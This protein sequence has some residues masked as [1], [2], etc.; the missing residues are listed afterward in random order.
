MGLL[1]CHRISNV[2]NL[3]FAREW[4]ATTNGARE[5]ANWVLVGNADDV[6]ERKQEGASEGI[7]DN[8]F[9]YYSGA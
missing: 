6:V 2:L 7:K 8:P 5:V 9:L 1:S 4:R 3:I